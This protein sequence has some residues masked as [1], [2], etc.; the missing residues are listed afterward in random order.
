M[1]PPAPLT[2]ARTVL[3]NQARA[4]A[5]DEGVG[6][7]WCITGSAH[8]VRH[9]IRLPCCPTRSP[10]IG[11]RAPRRNAST[12]EAPVA[13]AAPVR[14]DG[15]APCRADRSAM[16]RPPILPNQVPRSQ[17]QR[18]CRLILCGFFHGPYFFSRAPG[19]L[20]LRTDEEA[21]VAAAEP[22]EA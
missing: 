20:A 13:A 11:L 22:E 18:L 19:G 12:A 21:G 2:T 3:R 4:P 15:A 6:G 16:L 1:D 7:G 8:D 10:V 17:S 14:R 5:R 9:D